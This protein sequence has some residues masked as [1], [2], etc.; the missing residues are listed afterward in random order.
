MALDNS[1]LKIAENF[2]SLGL[3]KPSSQILTILAR[4]PALS[5][6]EI[7]RITELSRSPIVNAIHELTILNWIQREGSKSSRRYSLGMSIFAI[8]NQLA[9]QKIEQHRE[10]M[11]KIQELSAMFSI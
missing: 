4:V 8:I 11:L 7:S 2:T 6:M 1:D 10:N 9:I 3:S 5:L